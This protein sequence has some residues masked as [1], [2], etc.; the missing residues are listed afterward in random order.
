[1]RNARCL[2]FLTVFLAL[3]SAASGQLLQVEVVTFAAPNAEPEVTDQILA[4]LLASG[5][6]DGVTVLEVFEV[7]LESRPVAVRR[8]FAIGDGKVLFCN[9]HVE[10]GADHATAEIRELS[11]AIKYG[12]MA[13]ATPRANETRVAF[14]GLPIVE[15]VH[16][17]AGAAV[18]RHYGLRITL[19]SKE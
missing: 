15:L 1:M 18:T 7:Q 12:S 9:F 8:E 10:L 2:A 6:V 14:T 5:R 17:E 16:L 19:E 4:Q 13:E 11:F 3:A